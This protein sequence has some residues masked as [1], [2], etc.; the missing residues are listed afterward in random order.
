MMARKSG[1]GIDAS[2][3][4]FRRRR[5]LFHIAAHVHARKNAAPHRDCD[6][7]NE[8]E[9]GKD[10]KRPMRPK[11]IRFRG[12]CPQK[13]RDAFSILHSLLKTHER[14]MY[15]TA[16]RPS[17]FTERD[18]VLYGRP[19]KLLRMRKQRHGYE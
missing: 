5:L 12:R 7:E 8:P 6:D 14:R 3:G 10:R 19:A 18:A 16:Q 17:P 11:K 4:A 1:S 15:Y 13:S 9:N 2:H